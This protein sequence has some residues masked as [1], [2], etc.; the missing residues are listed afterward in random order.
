MV[1]IDKWKG[2]DRQF[3]EPKPGMLMPEVA[4]FPSG[5]PETPSSLLILLEE[6][7]HEKAIRKMFVPIY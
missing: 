3:M 7:P 4:S 2:W 5:G 6:S 1:N